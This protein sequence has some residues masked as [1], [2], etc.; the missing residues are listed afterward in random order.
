MEVLSLNPPTG[1]WIV[2]LGPGG[3]WAGA[4]VRAGAFWGVQDWECGAGA[5]WGWAGLRGALSGGSDEQGQVADSL[6]GG[7]EGVLPGPVERQAQGGFKWSSQ[8]LDVEVCDGQAV[9]VVGEADGRPA[10]KVAG[11]SA[12]S[13]GCGA[14]VLGEDRRGLTSEDAADRVWGVGFRR[15]ALVPRT[16]GNANSLLG[17]STGRYLSFSEREEIALLRAQGFGVRAI[18]REISRSPSTVSRELRRNAATRGANLEYRA[19]V[20]QWKAELAARRLG[21]R[22]WSSMIGSVTTCRIAS[23]VLSTQ[24]MGRWS[25]RRLRPGRAATGPADRIG[26]GRAREP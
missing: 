7:G 12:D 14:G 15:I 10:M 8:H 24:R 3:C 13:S 9:G 4:C 16:W 19:G 2:G 23:L 11:A 17:P 1:L 18:A 26:C 21:L 22:N 25:D 6:Q 5:G 20:A